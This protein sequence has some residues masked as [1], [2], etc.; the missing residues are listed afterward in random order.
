MTSSWKPVLASA[1]RASPPLGEPGDQ[2][3]RGGPHD[4]AR[5]ERGA[6]VVARVQADRRQAH[7]HPTRPSRS[8]ASVRSSRRPSKKR[9]SASANREPAGSAVATRSNKVMH[10]QNFRVVGRAQDL[11][12]RPAAAGEHQARAV[13]QARAEDGVGEIGR[14]PRPHRPGRSAPPSR[15]GRDPSA[16]ERRTTS[17]GCACCPPP[18]RHAPRRRHAPAPRRSGGATCH[19]AAPTRSGTSAN[20]APSRGDDSLPTMR[21]G[22]PRR[23]QNPPSTDTDAGSRRLLPTRALGSRR[24]RVVVADHSLQSREQRPTCS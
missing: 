18:A 22:R 17:S 21:P 12:R 20:G 23:G 9:S 2:H 7:A 13:D 24:Q 4:A 1:S 10:E 19:R 11:Q 14:R 6:Q 5:G 15:F 16:A 3:L 8:S